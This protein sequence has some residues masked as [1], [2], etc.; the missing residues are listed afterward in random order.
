MADDLS[1]LPWLISLA[2]RTVSTVRRNVAFALGLKVVF[3][4]LTLSGAGSLWLAIAADM[5]ASLLVIFYG[6][7]LLA[8]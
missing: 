5:G 3:V 6:L 7:R 1:R 8:S 2:R 4:I